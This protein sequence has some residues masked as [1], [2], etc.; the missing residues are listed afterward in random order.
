MAHNRICGCCA[1]TA[2]VE[3]AMNA[4]PPPPPVAMAAAAAA[5]VFLF[6]SS[7]I[8]R[9]QASKFLCSR[10]SSALLTILRSLFRRMTSLSEAG[11]PGVFHPF[12][13]MSPATLVSTC[14][15][16]FAYP[17]MRKEAC[18]LSVFISLG[19][20][21]LIQF[22]IIF[23]YEYV[24]HPPSLPFRSCPAK[25]LPPLYPIFFRNAID[26]VHWE[27][28]PEIFLHR[29]DRIPFFYFRI[30]WLLFLNC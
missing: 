28:F 24:N 27:F 14:Q 13:P 16:K 20:Y 26:K 25:R 1:V 5:D 29:T 7:S 15:P 11:D 18:A 12:P 4:V 10:V 19:A 9:T 22:S 6:S 23:Y 2:K 3:P 21:D 17:S 8:S 30:V